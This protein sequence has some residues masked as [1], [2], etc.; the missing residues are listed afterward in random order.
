MSVNSSSGGEADRG[1]GPKA[2]QPVGEVAG[3]VFGAGDGGIVVIPE[4]D[5][6]V[7]TVLGEPEKGSADQSEWGGNGVVLGPGSDCCSSTESS[8]SIWVD[9]F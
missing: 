9:I 4:T 8:C 7:K 5:V 1:G 2:D 6:T 3:L